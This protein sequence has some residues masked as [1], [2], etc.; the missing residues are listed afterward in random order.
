MNKRF[1]SVLTGI[2]IYLILTPALPLSAAE[3]EPVSEYAAVIEDDADLL[4][5]SEEAALLLELLPIT[6]YAN[7]A[8][9]T[10]KEHSF[11]STE[12]YAADYYDKTF[13]GGTN[14]TVFLIDMDRRFIYIVSDGA[15]Y[16]TV[17]RSRAETITDNVYRYASRGDY[18]ACAEEAFREILALLEGG[19]IA[20]PMKY[21]SNAFL[22]ISAAL[23]VMFL[24]VQSVTNLRRP[25]KNE[26]REA[27]VVR[28]TGD[29]PI[30]EKTGTTRR[31]EPISTGSGGGSGGSGGGG[32]GGFSGGGGG[33]SF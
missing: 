31:Y 24:I 1:C 6:E 10:V 26:L 4:S 19:R 28:F 18:Y 3:S 15:A 5:D 11:S 23:L 30:V 29:A 33:H 22:A 21:A 9:H 8:F 32:G 13:G 2:F 27:A 16:R 25:K 14:G 17:T 20:E 7:V 12:S